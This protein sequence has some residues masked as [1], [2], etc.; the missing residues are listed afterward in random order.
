MVGE[1]RARAEAICGVRGQ[2]NTLIL[3][4]RAGKKAAPKVEEAAAP[5]LLLP[6]LLPQK[7]L[8]QSKSTQTIKSEKPVVA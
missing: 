4:R 1:R 5:L 2:R 8:P 7:L 3:Y 6:R